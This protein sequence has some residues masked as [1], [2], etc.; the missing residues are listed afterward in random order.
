MLAVSN[1]SEVDFVAGAA[2][3][4]LNN[5]IQEII[6]YLYCIAKSYSIIKNHQQHSHN[7]SSH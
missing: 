5:L 3:S 1:Y 6:L 7:Q 4:E 2:F